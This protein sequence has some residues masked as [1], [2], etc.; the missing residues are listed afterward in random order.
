MEPACFIATLNV[1]H[2]IH[3]RHLC[4]KCK[5]VGAAGT[6]VVGAVASHTWITHYVLQVIAV[7]WT[8]ATKPVVSE[9]EN[10]SPQV[11][12]FFAPSFWL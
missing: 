6:L 9:F 12:L 8:A 1:V 4:R 2:H 10:E 7:F 5:Y 3:P 11:V